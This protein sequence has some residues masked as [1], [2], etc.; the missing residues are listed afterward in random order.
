MTPRGGFGGGSTL[1]TRDEGRGGMKGLGARGGRER[2]GLGGMEGRETLALEDELDGEK[3]EEVDE[4][5][6]DVEMPVEDPVMGVLSF[7]LAGKGGLE[8]NGGAV[9]GAPALML[10]AAELS[11][12]EEWEE[13]PDVIT[14]L[15]GNAGLLA[16]ADSE[17]VPQAGDDAG[18]DDVATTLTAPG[19]S[20][21]A[22]RPGRPVLM[23]LGGWTRAGFVR[24][25]DDAVA[26]AAWETAAEAREE[27]AGK[28][29]GGAAPGHA[30]GEPWVLG[31]RTGA[32]LLK[33]DDAEGRGGSRATFGVVAEA[34]VEATVGG[35]ET[36]LRATENGPEVVELTV[37]LAV[38]EAVGVEE[39]ADGGGGLAALDTGAEAKGGAKLS[40]YVASGLVT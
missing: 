7:G 14:G 8:R 23:L 31:V 16:G 22:L 30:G 28:L 35:L 4:V 9:E 15:A 20:R 13:E 1:R 29:G 2:T 32:A 40:L 12:E 3:E 37:V 18:G 5:V 24:G 11:W 38:A 27:G 39:E 21:G 33:E 6:R 19:G 34:E 26:E 25:M 36:G 10:L 17:G